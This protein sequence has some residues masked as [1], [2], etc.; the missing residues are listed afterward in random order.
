MPFTYQ[1][2]ESVS[3]TVPDTMSDIWVPLGGPGD[4]L[5]CGRHGPGGRRSA[6]RTPASKDL[7]G[8]GREKP[9]R[10]ATRPGPQ[11]AF[12]S[13]VMNETAGDNHLRFVDNS[14]LE[15]P[16]VEP[17]EVRTQAGTKIGT[18][19]G[20]IVDPAQ[21]RVR[22][23]VVDRGRVFHKRCL[24]PMPAARLDAEHHALSIDIDDTDP[25]EWERFDPGTFPR[26][27]DDD[28]ITAMFSSPA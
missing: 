2:L 16:L 8:F 15:S 4:N 19:D 23:L 20:V 11:I 17:L 13:D 14:R 3:D 1:N 7:D 12:Q 6:Q 27:S 26:F 25:N 24:I 9:C 28:L 5:G 22:F 18:F 10:N 21:R